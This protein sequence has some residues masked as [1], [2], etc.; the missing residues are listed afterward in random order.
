MIGRFAPAYLDDD[1]GRP[2]WV[3]IVVGSAPTERLAPLARAWLFHG[4]LLVMAVIRQAVEDAPIAPEGDLAD[5][6]EDV[7]YRYYCGDGRR[8]SSG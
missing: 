2:G 6:D 1:S 3:S 4:R 7:L 5:T 8:D